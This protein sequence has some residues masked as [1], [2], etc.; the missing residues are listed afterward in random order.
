MSVFEI[1]LLLAATAVL[2][3]SVVAGNVRGVLWIIAVMLDAVLS[4]AYGKTGLPYPEVIMA[5]LD[6]TVC[7][8]IW[9]GAANKWELWLFSLMQFSMLVSILDLA[10]G[11]V[12]PDWIDRE[13][14]LLVLE[15]INYAVLFLIG[16]VSSFAISGR[17]GG[18]AFRPWHRLFSAD[19][20]VR[21]SLRK[22]KP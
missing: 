13:T 22:D 17:I 18:A 19:Y 9:L 14:Y 15:I 7:I 2:L 3:L 16:G 20:F 12:V 10:A 21:G 4:D 6:F 1:L 8:A 5:A 11:I